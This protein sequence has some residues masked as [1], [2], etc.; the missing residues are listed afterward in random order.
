MRALQED[1][2]ESPLGF[3]WIRTLEAGHTEQVEACQGLAGL[4]AHYS[5]LCLNDDK[6]IL[7]NEEQDEQDLAEMI[8]ESSPYLILIPKSSSAILVSASSQYRCLC[9]LKDAKKLGKAPKLAD[10]EAAKEEGGEGA[11]PFV[12]RPRRLSWLY[13]MARITCD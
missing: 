1:T 11:L 4:R 10:E 9:L 5:I 8:S 7:K 3:V 6:E 12:L 13:P 2:R